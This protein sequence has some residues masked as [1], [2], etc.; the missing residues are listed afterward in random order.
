MLDCLHLSETEMRKR[1]EPALACQTTTLLFLCF[2]CNQFLQVPGNSPS[3]NEGSVSPSAEVMWMHTSVFA[4][5][6]LRRSWSKESD[7]CPF[8]EGDTLQRGTDCE[9]CY[10]VIHLSSWQFLVI[11][12]NIL[13]SEKEEDRDRL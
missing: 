13:E 11:I 3:S 7:L 1:K 8:L 6:A 4:G 2:M 10:F 12:S 9:G 5:E